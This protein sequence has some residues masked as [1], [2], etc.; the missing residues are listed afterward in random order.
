[1]AVAKVVYKAVAQFHTAAQHEGGERFFVGLVSALVIAQ[2]HRKARMF[3]HGV[4]A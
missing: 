1:L 3:E 4:A 2:A